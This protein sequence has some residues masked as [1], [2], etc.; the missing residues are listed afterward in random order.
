MW[1]KLKKIAGLISVCFF[2]QLHDFLKLFTL[3]ESKAVLQNIHKTVD[4][5]IA[6]I[7][8]SF[9]ILQTSIYLQHFLYMQAKTGKKQKGIDSPATLASDASEDTAMLSGDDSAAATPPADP[10]SLE[11]F[12][13]S[14]EIKAALGK[15]GIASLFDIQAQTLS[16]VLS[17]KDVLGRARY[18]WKLLA[19]HIS[20][21]YFLVK[22]Q[23][24]K[25]E[26]I[27]RERSFRK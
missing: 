12:P 20:L 18:V 21:Q 19:V 13:L 9:F 22:R 2:S 8:I 4:L 3:N 26:F 25:R 15:K 7:V 16:H 24:S 10:L 6:S 17:G 27:V 1:D 14:P 11:N 5:C 23:V